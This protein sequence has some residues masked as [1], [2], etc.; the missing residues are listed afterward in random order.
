MQGKQVN[1]PYPPDGL[2][3]VQGSDTSQEA[4][5]S[6][7]DDLGRLEGL[8]LN[9]I[10]TRGEHGATDDELEVALGLSHQ[11]ASARRR[12]LVLKGL[13]KDSGRRRINRSGRRG[14][15]WVYGQDQHEHNPF[16]G[17]VKRTIPPRPSLGEF[18]VAVSDLRRAVVIAMRHGFELRPACKKLG[19]WLA[20]L[21]NKEEW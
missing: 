7:T 13:V 15:V 2:P 16:L 4:A 12:T 1:L 19:K 18:K 20:Y 14:A 11:C 3:F 10:I 21:A 17:P 9:H 5:E 8:V 6:L